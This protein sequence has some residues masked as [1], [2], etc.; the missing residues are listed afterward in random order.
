MNKFIIVLQFVAGLLV[1][2]TGGY[3]LIPGGDNFIFVELGM[4]PFGRYLI[5]ILEVLAAL[6]LFSRSLCAY[7]AF[8]GTGLMLGALIA[9]TTILGIQVNGDGGALFGMLIFVL[10]SCLT[11]VWSK[12]KSI[13]FLG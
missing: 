9:H 2:Y 8:L 3:K 4:E 12:R 1:L 11:I 10:I 7:G 5:G 6:M 13:S